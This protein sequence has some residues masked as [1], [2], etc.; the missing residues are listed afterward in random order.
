M[1]STVAVSLDEQRSRH[2]YLQRSLNIN[3]ADTL[4]NVDTLYPMMG[5][6]FQTIKT[7]GYFAL[8]HKLSKKHLIKFGINADLF[9][10]NQ[11]DS[12]LSDLDVPD[13]FINRWDS[14]NNAFMIQPFFNGNIVQATI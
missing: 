7:S 6:Q 14:Q 5:Y 12:V 4:I 2:E 11:I 9:S 3:G 10:F 13:Q 1:S 8:N